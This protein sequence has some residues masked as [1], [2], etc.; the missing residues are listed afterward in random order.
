[1]AS[2]ES[3][4]ISRLLNPFV[5][6][7]KKLELELN[8]PTCLNIL[9]QPMLL[10]CDHILCSS[11][12]G[13]SINDG[14]SCPNCRQPYEQKDLRPATH[15]EKFLTIYKN[16]SSAISSLQRSSSFDF[17]G[18]DVPTP[19]S[20]NNNLEKKRT[21]FTG[22]D[23]FVDQ[24]QLSPSIDNFRDSDSDSWDEGQLAVKRK[25]ADM[26]P[27]EGSNCGTKHTKFND[28]VELNDQLKNVSMGG[29]TKADLDGSTIETCIFCHSF[30]NTE[31]SGEMLHYLNG[32]QIFENQAS[33]PNVLHVHRKC[34]D[35]AP[36]VYY[37]GE[38]VVNLEAELAR[39]SKIKCCSCGLKGAALGCYVKSCK[40]SFHVPCAYQILEC[41]WDTENYLV[42]CPTHAS[43]RLP[44]DKPKTKKSNSALVEPLV[45]SDYDTLS[46]AK[47]P[48]TI[49]MSSSS[50]SKDWMICGS[51]LSKDEKV[52]LEKFARLSGVLVTYQWKQNVT[53]VIAATNEDGACIRTMK[54]L[55]AILN[56]RWVLNMGWIK[57]CLEA[58]HLVPEENYEITHDTYDCINGPKNGRIRA[59]QKSPKVFNRL[60]FHFSGFFEPSYK[61][62]LE[63]LATEAGGQ[64]L[65]KFQLQNLSSSIPSSVAGE[66]EKTLIV[67][68]VEPPKD[69]NPSKIDRVLQERLETAE[70]LALKVGIVVRHT[71][72]LNAIAA[73]D[74]QMLYEK[75]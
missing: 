66:I 9:N 42:L 7:L 14:Y 33:Q 45:S 13:I 69:S 59:M 8:C 26:S 20:C 50:L 46:N 6:H 56:G 44:C 10:P 17:F 67:Y 75:S 19:I 54:Y 36:Q 16:M 72:F 37:S 1:M 62:N 3:E 24:I 2:S 51:D 49:W 40:R 12:N 32:E 27:E 22:A 61:C 52:I 73:N 25:F 68:S 57:A 47:R 71:V 23:N 53:H 21:H 29:N 43:R 74:L 15:I 5:L 28:S 34:I 18:L 11:C 35:W 55:M 60:A 31:A 48:H 30:R 65:S 41:R 64:V 39:S 4:G 58:E 70:A 63:N 38:K